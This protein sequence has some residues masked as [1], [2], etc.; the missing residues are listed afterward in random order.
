[1]SAE[2][3]QR[4]LKDQTRWDERW[5]LGSA[6]F[7]FAREGEPETHTFRWLSGPEVRIVEMTDVEEDLPPDQRLVKTGEAINEALA[8][9]VKRLAEAGSCNSDGFSRLIGLAH[10]FIRRIEVDAGGLECPVADLL[11]DDWQRQLVRVDV[12]HDVAVTQRM[13]R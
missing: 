2:T 4:K 11:L 5:S 9:D 6:G 1:M 10:C 13:H 12:V 8:S 7:L 3:R